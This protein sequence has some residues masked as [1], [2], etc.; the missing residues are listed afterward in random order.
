MAIMPGLFH[1][2]MFDTLTDEV[3]AALAASVPFPTRLGAGSEYARMAAHIIENAMLN[4]SSIRLDGA[5][6]LAPK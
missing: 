3:R 5:I 1:T 2:P 6:R 4:G